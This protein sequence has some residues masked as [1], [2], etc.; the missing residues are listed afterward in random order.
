MITIG[1]WQMVLLPRQGQILKNFTCLLISHD[2]DL[3][4]QLGLTSA[5]VS[6]GRG[7]CIVKVRLLTI[8]LV[9]GLHNFV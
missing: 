6:L 5:P 2:F 7:T 1:E 8:L 3:S 9:R 4:V